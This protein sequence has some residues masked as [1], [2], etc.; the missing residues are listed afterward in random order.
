MSEPYGLYPLALQV[1]VWRRMYENTE[2]HSLAH[3]VAVW[4]RMSGPLIKLWE[5]WCATEQHPCATS[6]SRY[7]DCSVGSGD[8]KND[9]SDAT[10]GYPSSTIG[11]TN[12]LGQSALGSSVS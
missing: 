8:I 5:I 7:P 11:F 3:Q 2:M 6:H 4:G 1:H 12:R 9:V 10:L